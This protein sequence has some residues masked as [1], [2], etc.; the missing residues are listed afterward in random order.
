MFTFNHRGL[1]V[2][3]TIII[4]SVDEFEKQFVINLYG[5]NRQKLFERYKTYCADLKRVCSNQ[6]I[7]QW[8]DGSYVTKARNP[9]DIDLVF[10]LDYET[11]KT[12]ETELKQFVYP[13]SIEQYGIDGYLIVNYADDSKYAHTSNADKA[14]WIDHF[15]KTKPNRLSKRIPKGFL[16]III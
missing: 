16:E 9:A 7:T 4:S 2:P 5:D 11:V 15:G 12:K 14:Y 8:I 1:L 3:E 13:Q 10:F 6:A